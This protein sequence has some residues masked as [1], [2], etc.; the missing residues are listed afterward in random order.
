MCFWGSYISYGRNV[1]R[2]VKHTLPEF[3]HR[4]SHILPGSLTQPL[5]TCHPKRKVV[6]QPSFFRGYVKL[7]RCSHIWKEIHFTKQ[8]PN[9][10]WTKKKELRKQ[11]LSWKGPGG[12]LDMNIPT[13]WFWGWKAHNIN[14][15]YVD[16]SWFHTLG[17]YPDSLR[18]AFELIVGFLNITN[19]ILR[20][21][22]IPLI[23][24]N[25]PLRFP[26]LP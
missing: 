20:G 21:V 19:R 5:K 13:I 14:C 7:W 17:G 2:F 25:V 11:A 22:G 23:F 1:R 16:D 6:F 9:S 15:S 10:D 18:G 24:P 3:Q 4:V 26:N 8:T 12:C